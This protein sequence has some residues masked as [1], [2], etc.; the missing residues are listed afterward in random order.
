MLGFNDCERPKHVRT[1]GGQ[2]CERLRTNVA[3]VGFT[4]IGNGTCWDGYGVAD[5][6]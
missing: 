1:K 6:C 5:A 4:G 3:A 2:H